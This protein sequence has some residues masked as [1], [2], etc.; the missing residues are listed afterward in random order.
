MQQMQPMNDYSQ[1]INVDDVVNPG[2]SYGASYGSSY[3]GQ[4]Q[5]TD[6]YGDVSMVFG[7]KFSSIDD[8]MSHRQKLV[9]LRERAM[10]GD[11][12]N[13]SEI[14]DALG[15]MNANQLSP[16]QRDSLRK[17]HSDYFER[18]S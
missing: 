16:E 5:P 2:M 12:I 18:I 10:A 8:V 9:M 17:A 4:S 13:D 1:S 7:P 15:F 14:G 11:P 3:S 6:K